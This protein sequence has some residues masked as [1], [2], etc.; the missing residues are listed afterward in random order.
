MKESMRPGAV[1][2]A[3]IVILLLGLGAYVLFSASKNDTSTNGSQSNG[4]QEETGD[5]VEGQEDDPYDDRASIEAGLEARFE[6]IQGDYNDLKDEVALTFDEWSA[7]T[8]EAW[9][10]S[11]D[12]INLR[13]ATTQNRL[14]MLTQTQVR[15][16]W[17]LIQTE[18]DASIEELKDAYVE[19][20]ASFM[21]GS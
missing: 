11:I 21:T 10:T 14:E 17:V 6:N 8:Q 1:F 13:L 9:Q 18:V 7:D 12:G 20:R 2:I 4:T 19:L 3:I 16:T 15:D 5:P